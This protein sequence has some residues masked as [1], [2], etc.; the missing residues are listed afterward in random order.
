MHEI[1]S[2]SI[3]VMLMR[4]FNHLSIYQIILSFDTIISLNLSRCEKAFKTS[5]PSTYIENGFDYTIYPSV[6]K[7]IPKIKLILKHVRRQIK[8]RAIPIK[9]KRL[10]N[11]VQKQWKWPWEL[12]IW[13]AWMFQIIMGLNP[14]WLSLKS[15]KQ[16]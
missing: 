16:P 14:K 7:T 4:T 8:E 3:Q 2:H 5:L 6:K 11:Q 1:F 13:P 10:K 12:K 15:I 9:L